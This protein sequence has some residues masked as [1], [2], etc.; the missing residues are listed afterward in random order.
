MYACVCVSTQCPC[1]YYRLWND[2][3]RMMR[4]KNKQKPIGVIVVL[5]SRCIACWRRWSRGVFNGWSCAKGDGEETS[6]FL[7]S[8]PD[9]VSVSGSRFPQVVSSPGA[10]L[11]SLETVCGE[12]GLQHP[13][14]EPVRVSSPLLGRS[15]RRDQPWLTVTL[16]AQRMCA[17]PPHP[18]LR[19]PAWA[20]I[21]TNSPPV[22]P[23]ALSTILLAW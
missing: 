20:P 15:G 1:C 5:A 2:C 17:A 22:L 21:Q 11:L 13:G 3:L 8:C 14:L 7:A 19:R 6:P 16:P 18:A 9:G 12:V 10:L 23:P 4:Y